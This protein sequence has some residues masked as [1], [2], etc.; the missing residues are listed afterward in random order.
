MRQR[1]H[2][3]IG[4]AIAGALISAHFFL[5]ETYTAGWLFAIGVFRL[6][7]SLKW[8]NR[9]TL[10]PFL[11]FIIGFSAYTYDG[12]LSIVACTGGLLMTLGSFANSMRSLRLF[13]IAGS[14]TWLIHNFLAWTPVGILMEF[15]F[16]TSNLVG[17]YRFF[18]KNRHGR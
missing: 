15:V 12:Y 7:V 2:L 10:A 4:Q 17:Y 8:R 16:L 5:L 13:Y 18:I 3:I 11:L 6:M 1:H 9:W 14:S